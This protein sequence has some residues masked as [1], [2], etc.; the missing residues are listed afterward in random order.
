[1][2]FAE[3]PPD[4]DIEGHDTAHKCQ[5]VSSLC[6][7]SRVNLD[8][9]PV[10]GITSI[11]KDDIADA[12][13]MGYVIKLLAVY[14]D[15]GDA[16][17]ARVHPTLIPKTHQLASVLNEFN[18]VFVNGDISDA[19]MYY[20]KGAGRMPTASAVV[21]DIADIAR[22]GSGPVPAPFTYTTEKPLQSIG[23]HVGQFYLRISTKDVKGVV[24][25]VGD[26]LAEHDVSIASFVQPESHGDA[27]VH[28]VIVT[29]EAP[30]AAL[31]SAL[32]KIDSLDSTTEPTHVLRI[33][34]EAS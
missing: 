1:M 32:Q 18:A 4:L 10:E 2:G 6:S 20:G 24:G 29:H 22:R 3:T 12:L 11:S 28:L 25:T 7:G 5:I 15:M 31:R 23:K 33:L 26:I 13:D 21:A 14:R 27:P 16:I 8:D 9:I 19:T 34:E 30:E 17:D